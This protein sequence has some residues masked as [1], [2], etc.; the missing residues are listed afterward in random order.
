VQFPLVDLLLVVQVDP[1]RAELAAAVELVPVAVAVELVLV[2]LSAVAGLVEPAA[3][4]V[5]TRTTI[6]QKT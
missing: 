5:P 6:N 3:V 1:Q 2:V 4:P